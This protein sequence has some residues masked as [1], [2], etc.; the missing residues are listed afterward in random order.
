MLRATLRRGFSLIELMITLTVVAVVLLLAAPWIGDWLQNTQI[1]N[2]ADSMLTGIKL[3]RME[4]LKRNSP[5]LFQM[6]SS[7]DAS[8]GLSTSGANWVVSVNSAVGLCNGD[9]QSTPFIIRKKA[10][11]EGTTN[12]VY[13]ATQASIGFDSLGRVTPAP[14]SD[15]VVFVTNPTGGDCV[16]GGP[17][18]CQTIVVT[19]GGQTRM[20]DPAVTDATDPRSC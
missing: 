13:A 10:S 7:T 18:R 20:C 15:I 19:A 5:V 12:V 2:A 14:A 16:P 6:M 4:A 9:S 1:R 8:C 17:M 11:G 3:A